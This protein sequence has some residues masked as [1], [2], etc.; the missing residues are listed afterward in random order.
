MIEKKD[1][2]GRKWQLTINNPKDNGMPHE[3]IKKI[4]EQFTGCLYYCMSDEIGEEGTYHTH[5]YFALKSP[6]RFTTVKKRF[7]PAHIERA[8]G[9]SKENVDYVKKEGK[10][11]G[12]MK[13]ETSVPDSFEEWGEMPN[14]KSGNR[15]DMMDL[16]DMIKDGYSDY[17]ILEENAAYI[18]Q[19]DKIEK[20]RQIHKEE[21]YRNTFRNLEVTYIYGEP[22]IGKSRSVMEKYGYANVYR[23]TD[24]MH[25]FDGY[26]GQ[27]VIVFE[28]F[29]SS[30]V[31]ISDM[32]N[33][34]DGY[35]LEL[36]CRYNNKIACFT[37]VYLISN[38]PFPE[39]YHNI[40]VEHEATY[41]AFVRRI[42]KILLY[43]E[44]GIEEI[45]KP[46]SSGEKPD[47]ADNPFIKYNPYGRTSDQN[48]KGAS[49]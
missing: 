33:Y 8:N 13:A 46:Y 38:I 12:S 23:V 48:Q 45:P 3:T 22:G 30:A 47:P 15:N 49:I 24:Y 40:K 7:P 19:V 43:T 27:D 25:P 17:E 29:Y 18:L 39:Q 10:W 28:E 36:P 31:R 44:K 6:T 11:E 41:K 16:Y 34:L 4:M 32:L 42:S 14:D 1:Q 9:S 5:L 26:K 37:K 2:Q 35:P 20:V 21:M